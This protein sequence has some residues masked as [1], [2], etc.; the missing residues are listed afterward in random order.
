VSAFQEHSAEG[1]TAEEEVEDEWSI[2]PINSTREVAVSFRDILG[3]VHG[4]GLVGDNL[5]PVPL[6]MAALDEGR[7]AALGDEEVFS[8]P[9]SKRSRPSDNIAAA[10]GGSVGGGSGPVT[11][12][13]KSTKPKG[14][15]VTLF[16]NTTVTTPITNAMSLVKSRFCLSTR[17]SV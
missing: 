7:F 13:T 15:R 4:Y 8:P 10:G 9:G 17:E 6:T 16:G 12:G 14:T 2:P 1:E 11:T 5:G 3:I